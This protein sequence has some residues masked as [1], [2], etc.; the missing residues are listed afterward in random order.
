MPR[1]R[2]DLL[3]VNQGLAETRT[4]AQALI[5]AGTVVDAH[6]Q[7]VSK[8][9]QLL[10]DALVLRLKAAPREFVSRGGRKLEAALNAFSI[11]PR[12]QVCLDVGASTGGFTDC[13]LKR[14]AARVYAVDVGYGQ[15][16]WA[17]RQDPRVRVIERCN[18]RH[19]PL[20]LLPERP[21][22]V[23]IDV[24]FISLTLV[25]PRILELASVPAVI[26]A[27]VKPQF[28]VGRGKVGK[29]GI[30][31]DG[32]ARLEAVENIAAACR[33][34]GLTEIQTIESPIQGAD[35][36]VEYLL[37]GGVPATPLSAEPT[38]R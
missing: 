38:R 11:D 13:L 17:L 16:A 27:L 25:L 33:K 34:L 36:N 28:E 2:A 32:A 4:R 26:I 37:T 12:D 19:A 23:V 8:P 29:G 20:D 10:D 1:C 5:L 7:R 30:V 9:G 15:L 3:V 31:R 21:T 22:L 6:G 35:G 14:G 18:I 24:S